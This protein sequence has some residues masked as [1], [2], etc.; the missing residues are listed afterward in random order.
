MSKN[1]VSEADVNWKR[2][3]EVSIKTVDYVWTEVVTNLSQF[4][5]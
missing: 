4:T 3:L 1:L 2:T 5:P